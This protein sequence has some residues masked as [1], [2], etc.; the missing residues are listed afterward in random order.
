MIKTDF[1]NDINA[2]LSS[3]DTNPNDLKSL[4]D[5]VDYNLKHDEG[6]MPGMHPAW[7]TGQDMLE[8]CLTTHGIEDDIYHQA[9]AFI[10]Q[11]SREEGIDAALSSARRPLDGLLVP[12]YADGG[13]SCQLAAK[14]GY[15]MITIPAGLH[16]D[17]VVLYCAF[18]G[19]TANNDDQESPLV[20]VSSRPLAERTCWSSMAPP[21]KT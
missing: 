13:V 17:G 10:R 15:P 20:S 12:V 11:K 19:S 16:E 4:E 6:G 9:L 7:P 21:S 2:Y 5:I 3:L 18:V 1:Y 14:A 8:R